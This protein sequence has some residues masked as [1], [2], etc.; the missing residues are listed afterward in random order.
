MVRRHGALASGSARSDRSAR[1]TYAQNW[2]AY[3]AAQT[4]E[5]AR[6][7]DLLHGLCAGIE[8]PKQAQGRPRFQLADIVFSAV[9]KVYRTMSGR[10]AM[11]DLGEFRG[12][13][14]LR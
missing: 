2:S 9:M 1:P 6:V 14:Y 13:G 4:H 12:K 3:N 5:K 8:Q 10:R 11:S 7:T